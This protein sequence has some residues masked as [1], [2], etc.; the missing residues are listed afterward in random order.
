MNQTKLYF[1]DID[2]RRMPGFPSGGF[3][4]KALSSG[5]NIIYGP[6]G[7]GKTTL[8][9]AICKLLRPGDPPHEKQSLLATLQIDDQQYLLDLDH[10]QVKCQRDGI[11]TELPMLAPVVLG[12]RYVLALHDLIGVEDGRDLADQVVRES[13]GGYDLKRALAQLDFRDRPRSK[14]KLN[15]DLD[16][17]RGETRKARTNQEDLIHEER[18]LIELCIRRDEALE[19]KSEVDWIDKALARDASLTKLEQAQQRLSRF[20]SNI[21]KLDGKEVER[22]TKLRNSLLTMREK[23]QEEKNRQDE[24]RA[25]LTKSILPERGVESQVIG[26]L[27]LK[28]QHL[29]RLVATIS[30]HQQDLAE[31]RAESEKTKLRLGEDAISIAVDELDAA[32]IDKLLDF[33]ERSDKHRAEEVAVTKLRDWLGTDTDPTDLDAILNGIELLRDWRA[34][35]RIQANYRSPRSIWLTA[36]AVCCI[37]G[38][39]FAFL[40]DLSWFLVLLAAIGL[41]ILAFVPRKTDERLGELQRDFDGSPLDA[42]PQWTETTVT[43]RLWQL[44]DLWKRSAVQDEKSTR[45]AGLDKELQELAVRSE[46]L[47]SERALWISQL[48]LGDSTID[49]TTYLLARRLHEFQSAV[50]RCHGVE[51]KVA[52]VEQQHGNL[53]SKINKTLIQYSLP[54]ATDAEQAAAAVEQLDQLR[55]AHA[56]AQGTLMHCEK[57]L[58][59]IERQ[60]GEISDDIT[61]MFANLGLDESDDVELQRWIEQRG[62]FIEAKNNEARARLEFDL[63]D[64]IACTRTDLCEL[65]HDELVHRLHRHQKLADQQ[66]ALNKQVVEI[67]TRISEAKKRTDLEAALAFQQQFEDQLRNRRDEDYEAVVGN[68]LAEYLTKQER[69]TE[70]SQVFRRAAELFVEITHGRYKLLVDDT[71]PPAFRALDTDRQ[72]GL[73]LD[74]LSS[75]T[76]VHLLLAVRVA[77]VEQHESQWRLPL[78]FDETLANSDEQ[79]AESIIDA[80]VELCRAGRQIFYL[81]AQHDE[82]EKWLAILNRY[83][84]VPYRLFDLAEIRGFSETEHVPP[85]ELPVRAEIEIPKPDGSDWRNYGRKLAVP[86][87]DRRH[88]ISGVHLW[89]LI[90]DVDALYRLLRNGVNRWGQ[91]QTLVE[92]GQVDWLAEDSAIYQRSTAAA[93]VLHHAVEYW[94]VGRGKPIGREVLIR[95]GCVSARFIESVVERVEALKGDARALIAALEGGDVKGFRDNKRQELAEYLQSEG[96]LDERVVLTSQQVLEQ[97]LTVAFDLMDHGLLDLRRVEELVYLVLRNDENSDDSEQFSLESSAEEKTTLP[98]S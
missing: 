35:A 65:A 91:L 18:E 19:A 12:D 10:G 97:V 74:E 70:R 85:M 78:I 75:G 59:D 62:E 25:E 9:R 38:V 14:S 92:Y 2:L 77:F 71:D 7:S 6:N 20:P 43:E 82:V 28:C 66:Q 72:A 52:V 17:A 63:A 26:E 36:A 87:I 1:Q 81:T 53:L 15:R 39:T 33:V 45:W 98:D 4:V 83:D 24:T 37:V 21:E 46:E 90:D 79:R 60:I 42:L 76:R 51:E 86:A 44:Q 96:F 67:E 5:V 57:N 58:P 13:A 88:R 32:E 22:L 41:L 23:R 3:R 93:N 50:D 64:S 61:S 16:D 56:T 40:F 27:R 54:A 49:A 30:T 11:D 8:S 69:G 34:F 84:D 48:G 94:R 31:A 73:A 80:A 95:S 29:D 47:G 55:E 68:V 89:H